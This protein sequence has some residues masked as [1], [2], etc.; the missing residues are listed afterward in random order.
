MTDL[1]LWNKLCIR[2]GIQAGIVIQ[3]TDSV[4]MEGMTRSGK[5]FKLG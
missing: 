3:H 5:G 4:L 2:G 1:E